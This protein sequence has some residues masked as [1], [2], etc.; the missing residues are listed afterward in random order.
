MCCYEIRCIFEKT[1]ICNNREISIIFWKK[2]TSQTKSVNKSVSNRGCLLSKD[3]KTI[4]TDRPFFSL[5]IEAIYMI[6]TYHLLSL[7]NTCISLKFLSRFGFGHGSLLNLFAHHISYQK[8]F[9][10]NQTFYLIMFEICLKHFL[11]KQFM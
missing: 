11:Y 3:L 1:K 2:D 6:S 5:L 4:V 8:T 7:S 10:Y 9:S